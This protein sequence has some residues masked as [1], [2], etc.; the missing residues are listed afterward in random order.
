MSI[1]VIIPV[2]NEACTIEN[3]LRQAG[4]LK[5]NFDIIVVDGGSSDS[6]VTIAGRYA[7]VL[8]S[9]KGRSTQMNQ[10][11]RAAKGDFLLFLHADT[12]LPEGAFTAVEK[13]MADPR[14]VG[15][16]FTLKLD[17][18]GW[19]YRMIGSSIN[20][21]DRL[22]RG[23][24]GDQAIFIRKTV[25]EML[26]GYR[27]MPLMEDLDIGHRMYRYGKVVRLPLTVITSARRWKNNGVFRTILL[28]WVLRLGYYFGQAPYWL[29]RFYGDVR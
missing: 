26:G 3:T 25:F 18:K 12:S 9:P 22:F 16:R 29:G 23:F 5:G 8:R 2:F 10:G 27:D 1:S 17:E 14:V 13:A 6:T 28:M 4:S 11:A 21:R 20:L 19:R 24:T 15:G 7:R